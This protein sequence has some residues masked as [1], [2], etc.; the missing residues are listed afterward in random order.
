MK[1]V[2]RVRGN[3]CEWAGGLWKLTVAEFDERVSFL[4]FG[5]K[6]NQ[7]LAVC[8]EGRQR[9]GSFSA[10]PSREKGTM[11]ISMDVQGRGLADGWMDDGGR[12]GLMK[13]EMSI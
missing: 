9:R 1:L 4:A 12:G 5:L 7:C 6:S 3:W 13:V 2:N 10:P 8:G 11:W